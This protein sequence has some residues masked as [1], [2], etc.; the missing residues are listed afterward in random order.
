MDGLRR[1]LI[2][3]FEIYPRDLAG[4][5]EAWG[6]PRADG[7]IEI[8]IIERTYDPHAPWFAYV[9][10]MTPPG[11]IVEEWREGDHPG[12]QPGFSRLDLP[13]EHELEAS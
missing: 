5:V 13:Q 9:V 10:D 4:D 2:V 12:S 7:R 1:A 3:V 11:N 8:R 6:R